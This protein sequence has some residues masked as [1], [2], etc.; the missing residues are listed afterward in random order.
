[1]TDP[2][3]TAPPQPPASTRDPFGARLRGAVA[4]HGPLC[5]G[6]DPHAALLR[7]WGLPETVDGL[8][9]FAATCVEA[10]A[11]R[12]A[13]VKPQSAF[14]ERFGSGGVAVLEETVAA[15]RGSGTITLLDVKRGD[16]GSTLTAYAEAYLHDD[17]PL[18]VDAVT[19][20][21]YLGYESLRPALDLCADTGRGVFVLCLTSNPEAA[22][23]QHAVGE[24]VSVAR[25]IAEAAARDDAGAPDGTWGHVGL[26][27]GAT[28]GSAVRDLGVDLAAVRGPLLAPGF[29]A[30]GAGVEHLRGVFGP[31]LPQ[32]LPSASRTVLAAGPD[33]QHLRE[34]VTRVSQALERGGVGRVPAD[35]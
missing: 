18:A 19:L 1:M 11:G 24:G 4:E 25:A 13:L 35:G 27:V 31:A 22:S 14:F 15:L 2:T 3:Q 33:V 29:G 20:S 26:V 7:D 17:A 32:V 6:I 12:V 21:P 34:A 16:I 5:V 28:T 8:R 9:R 23:V 30:Q 10:F